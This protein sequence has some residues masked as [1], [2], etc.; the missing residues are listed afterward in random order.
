MLTAAAV[1]VALAT[2]PTEAEAFERIRLAC[3]QD[4]GT[5]TSR[6]ACVEKAWGKPLPGSVTEHDKQLDDMVFNSKWE[7]DAPDAGSPFTP[8]PKDAGRAVYREPEPE[9]DAVW[10]ERKKADKAFQR[11]IRSSIV[12]FARARRAEAFAEIAKE[13]KYAAIGGIE[14]QTKLYGLQ[15]QIRA[16]D[17]QLE[18]LGSKDVLPCTSPVPKAYVACYYERKPLEEAGKEDE[19]PC[20]TNSAAADVLRYMRLDPDTD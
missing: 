14:N 8:A 7:I 17:E 19:A 1:L 20:V 6:L 3:I 9:T 11:Q 12:C 18:K 15:Q 16:R 2:A 10:F 4:A 5:Y 13:K